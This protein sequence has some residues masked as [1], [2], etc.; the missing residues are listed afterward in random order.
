[1]HFAMHFVEKDV[2]GCEFI[3]AMQQQKIPA[4]LLSE[5]VQK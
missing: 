3:Y 4:P 5:Q 1:M 2:S